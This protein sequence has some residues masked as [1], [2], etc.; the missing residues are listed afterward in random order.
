MGLGS[1]NAVTEA[2]VIVDDTV[3]AEEVVWTKD[4][5]EEVTSSSMLPFESRKTP[6]LPA[7]HPGSS[8]EQ[9]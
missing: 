2:S 8:S 7:Q 6:R 1:E 9:Q 5:V 3:S 4:T